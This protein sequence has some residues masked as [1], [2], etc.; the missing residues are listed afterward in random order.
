M[1]TINGITWDLAFVLSN[2]DYLMRS[3]GS[4]TIGMT[5]WNDRTVYLNKSLRGAFM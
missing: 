4:V 5:D 2:S 1:F 3:D